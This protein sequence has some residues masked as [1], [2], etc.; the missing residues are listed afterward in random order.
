MIRFTRHCR[1]PRALLR[2]REKQIRT[3]PKQVWSQAS[4][5]ASA[6]GTSGRNPPGANAPRI[7]YSAAF[8]RCPSVRARAMT[9]S[10]PLLLPSRIPRTLGV[11]VAHEITRSLVGIQEPTRNAWS[12]ITNATASRCSPSESSFVPRPSTGSPPNCGNATPG[13]SE[14][15]RDTIPERL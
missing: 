7:S 6:A 10:F 12:A 14:L 4:F 8:E 5:S 3:I 2:E 11:E 13:T 1:P 15:A 9:M